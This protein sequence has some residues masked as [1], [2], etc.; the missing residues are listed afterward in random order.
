[1]VLRRHRGVDAGNRRPLRQR[2]ERGDRGDRD[3]RRQLVRGAVR[4]GGAHPGDPPVGQP[5]PALPERGPRLSVH[6][7]P[8]G[9]LVAGGRTH[10]RRDDSGDRVGYERLLLRCGLHRRRRGHRAHHQ[11]QLQPGLGDPAGRG[12]VTRTGDREHPGQRAAPGGGGDLVRHQRAAGLRLR[13]ERS[14]R[15]RRLVPAD[16]RRG[17]GIDLDRRPHGERL[18]GSAGAHHRWGPGVRWPVGERH[19]HPRRGWGNEQRVP[20]RAVGDARSQRDDRHHDRRLQLRDRPRRRPALRDSRAGQRPS[21]R[22]WRLATIPPR[23]PVDRRLVLPQHGSS[24]STRSRHRGRYGTDAG[25][26]GVLD[27]C[28]GRIGLLL[29][30]RRVPR[31]HGREGVEQAD[32]R[33]GS[34]P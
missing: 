15:I 19:R 3:D 6:G 5:G 30:R 4:P 34:D 8:G 13:A 29:R 31:V 7:R 23:S 12:H 9:E 14:E 2:A 33:H 11:R 10:P 25:R 26:Q 24:C 22:T 18:P 1:M 20:E 17:Q 16:G 27:R 28:V 32:R 21:E